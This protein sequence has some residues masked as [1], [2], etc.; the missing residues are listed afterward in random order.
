MATKK[1]NTTEQS[2]PQTMRWLFAFQKR[3]NNYYTQE[4]RPY[5]KSVD[6]DRKAAPSGYRFT[7]FAED[8]GYTNN[9]F[10]KPTAEEIAK[11]AGKK[12]NG[13]LIMY[14]ENRANKSDSAPRKKL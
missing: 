7:Q 1:K 12:K 2:A 4:E 11:Y 13:K 5:K 3:G 8:K 14:K 9:R 10:K 6:A